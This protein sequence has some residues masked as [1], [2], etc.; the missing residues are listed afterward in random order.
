[1]P[2]VKLTPKFVTEVMTTKDK[3]KYQDTVQNGLVLRVTPKGKV[4]YFIAT[5]PIPNRGKRQIEKKIGRVEDITLSAA[6]E[7][8]KAFLGAY[9]SQASDPMFAYTKPKTV[10][11]KLC[12]LSDVYKKWLLRYEKQKDT[13]KY[14]NMQNGYS[15]LAKI[16]Y[17]TD[18]KG[19][20]IVAADSL[21]D[22]RLDELTEKK[23]TSWQTASII[24]SQ[25]PI[26]TFY[27]PQSV[28]SA[29]GVESDVETGNLVTYPCPNSL[30][31]STSSKNNG[32]DNT[33]KIVTDNPNLRWSQVLYM[34]TTNWGHLQ[35]GYETIW[36]A[37]LGRNRDLNGDDIVQADEIRWYLASI[38]QLTAL[39]IGENALPSVIKLYDV[40]KVTSTNVP[41][42]HVASSSLYN[43]DNVAYQSS[44]GN[45]DM[46]WAEEGASR[47]DVNRSYTFN[48][49]RYSYDYRCVRNLGISLA[50]INTVPDDYVQVNRGSYSINGTTYNEYIIDVSRLDPNTI[51][52]ASPNMVLGSHTE[53]QDINRPASKFAVIYDRYWTADWNKVINET[54]TGT[55][56]ICPVGYRLPN[57]REL[58][59]LSMYFGPDRPQQSQLYDNLFLSSY[60]G[61]GWSSSSGDRTFYPART[62]Y[63][64]ESITGRPGF[65]VE[66]A[67]SGD[68]TFVLLQSKP[69]FFVRCVRDVTE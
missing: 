66:S 11:R 1:M 50:S 40:S 33:L 39:W 53:R 41:H 36:Y 62:E 29:W 25:M 4:Y 46:I 69:Q 52:A 67:T 17:A 24:F 49:K 59:L 60:Y 35:N 10:R 65:A 21:A 2:K 57:Q 32:R 5:I 54:S 44:K 7:Q 42:L 9:I 3:E 22:L 55:G 20:P 18:T 63:G 38:D 12:K 8:A 64:Y 37:C 43:D 56:R 27:N 47:G 31:E 15:V 19:K 51:R 48:E 14:E 58:L 6:R 61:S 28:S 16:Y 26:R 68:Y 30:T 13:S 34:G 23:I 45:V